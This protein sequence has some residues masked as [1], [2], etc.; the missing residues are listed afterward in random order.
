VRH[1]GNSRVLQVGFPSQAGRIGWMPCILELW[2]VFPAPVVLGDV[3]VN[4]NLS[5]WV[6]S[7]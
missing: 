1:P 4:L 2:A 5:S 3:N 7:S 6:S